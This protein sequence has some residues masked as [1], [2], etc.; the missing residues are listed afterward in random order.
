MNKT[1]TIPMASRRNFTAGLYFTL[2]FKDI[3]KGFLTIACKIDCLSLN[4][5]LLPVNDEDYN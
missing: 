5:N 4:S 2:F 1:L 3:I